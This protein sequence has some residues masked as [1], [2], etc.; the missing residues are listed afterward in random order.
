MCVCPRSGYESTIQ[1]EAVQYMRLLLATVHM[2]MDDI[3]FK[4][5]LRIR[6]YYYA[7]P[8]PGSK[9]CPYES[10]SGS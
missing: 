3:S 5:V 1:F 9:K 6:T 2:Y 7:D 4:A 10:G 8:D